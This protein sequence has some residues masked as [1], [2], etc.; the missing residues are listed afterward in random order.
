MIRQIFSGGCL[1]GPW[2]G[3]NLAHDAPFYRVALYEHLSVLD[4]PN[5]PTQ[6]TNIKMGVYNWHDKMKVWVWSG[7]NA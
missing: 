2:M 4:D 5:D 6:P 3:K 7:P 1:D